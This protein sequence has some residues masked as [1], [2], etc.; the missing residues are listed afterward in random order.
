MGIGAVGGAAARIVAQ[1]AGRADDA[2]LLASLM[3]HALPTSG[4]TATRS[5]AQ[6]M[7]AELDGGKHALDSAELLTKPSAI[8]R[9][10]NAAVKD[11]REAIHAIKN[12]NKYSG[13]RTNGDVGVHP[14]N[15]EVFQLTGRRGGAS[16]DSIGNILDHLR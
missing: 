5:A 15:G 9:A 14:T 6:R 10:Y 13:A 2:A 1:G 8:A 3:Q 16:T 4:G 7:A 12:G 11:V